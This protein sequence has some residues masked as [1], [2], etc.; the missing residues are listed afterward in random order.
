[1]LPG[2]AHAHFL[3]NPHLLKVGDLVPSGCPHQPGIESLAGHVERAQLAWAAGELP[4]AAFFAE[5]QSELGEAE[6]LRVLSDWTSGVTQTLPADSRRLF[7]FLCCLEEPD[8]TSEIVVPVWPNFL[9]RLR[10]PD[11]AERRSGNNG[12]AGVECNEPPAVATSGSLTL[13]SRSIR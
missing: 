5:G 13:L 7:E 12:V 1:M 9:T 4:L 10:R 11:Q 6:F 8:R 2:L 3:V